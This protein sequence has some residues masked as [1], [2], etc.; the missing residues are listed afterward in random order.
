[1]LRYHAHG[2]PVRPGL[3]VSRSAASAV[4]VIGDAWHPLVAPQP[5]DDRGRLDDGMMAAAVA[6]APDV[7]ALGS[8]VAEGGGAVVSRAAHE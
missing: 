4:G 6:P 1:M 3:H 7:E 8:H 5:V 2:W